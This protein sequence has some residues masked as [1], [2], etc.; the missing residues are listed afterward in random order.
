MPDNTKPMSYREKLS[1]L[2]K[3]YGIPAPSASCMLKIFNLTRDEAKL[4]DME[5][6]CRNIEQDRRRKEKFWHD[7]RK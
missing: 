1:F 5:E 4:A 7:R 6:F 3:R 2:C